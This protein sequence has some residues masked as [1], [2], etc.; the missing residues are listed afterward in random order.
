MKPA[1]VVWSPHDGF[2]GMALGE[3]AVGGADVG[4]EA[5]GGGAVG[6]TNVPESTYAVR[7]SALRM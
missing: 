4:G 6:G 3:A 7:L 5:V 2:K 1:A